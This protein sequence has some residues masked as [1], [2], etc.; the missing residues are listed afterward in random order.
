[1]SGQGSPWQSIGAWT[2]P[3]TPTPVVAG[4]T[5]T[6]QV[7]GT[8]ATQ[9]VLAY[10]APDSNPCTVQVSENSTLAPLVH[11]V[12]P[13]LF[14]GSNSDSRTGALSNGTSRVFVVGKRDTET[15]A[16]S[17]NYSRALQANT[18]HSFSVTCGSSTVTGTFTTQN[19]PLGMTNRDL[20]AATFPTVTDDLAQTIV[21]PHTGALLKKMNNSSAYSSTKFFPYLYFGGFVRMCATQPVGPSAGF[22]CAFPTTGGGP[23]LLWYITPS[24][25]SNYLGY[26]TINAQDGPNGWP[27][28]FSYAYPDI[29]EDG[30]L[31]TVSGDNSG[32]I[33]LLKGTFN[34][35]FGAV[36]GQ[37]PAT[38]Q[39]SNFTP[40]PNDLNAQMQAFDP[41][42]NPANYG[43]PG[44][45]PP[46]GNYLLLIYT[47]GQQDTPG[48][49]GV[50]DLTQG[51]IVAALNLESGPAVSYCGLHNS[52]V[53]GGQPLAN[54]G[55]HGLWGGAAWQGPFTTT[56]SSAID[57]NTTTIQIV[58]APVD[59][60]GRTLGGP[61]VGSILTFHGGA[62]E[63]VKVTSVTPNAQGISLQ[64]QRN[65]MP[66][67]PPW[68]PGTYQPTAHTA[69]ETLRAECTDWTYSGDL[70]MFWKFLQDPHGAN[71]GTGVVY[72]YQ[73]FGIGGHSDWGSNAEITEGWGIRTGALLQQIG[74]PATYSLQNSPTFGN[75]QGGCWG[76]S[77][78]M[79]PSYHTPGAQ[80]F[81]DGLSWD[82]GNYTYSD[83]VTPISGQLYKYRFPYN[84]GNFVPGLRNLHRKVVPTL[85][86]TGGT[87]LVDV[88]GPGSTISDQAADNY[89]YCIA[90]KAGECRTGSA[91]G[92]IFANVPA[93]D[94]LTCYGSDN[95]DPSV[96]DLCILDLPTYATSMVQI[97]FVPNH[98]GIGILPGQPDT[99]DTSTV[100]S[101]YSRVVTETLGGPKGTGLLFKTLP[102]GSWGFFENRT[103]PA[104]PYLMMAKIPPFTKDS[105]RRDVFVRAPITITP[106]TGQGIVSAEID[107]GYT[108]LNGK[109]SSRNEVCAV[110]SSTVDDTNPFSYTQSDSYVRAP[111][112]SSCTITLPVL[113]EHIAYYQVKYY[114][115]SGNF[116]ANGDSG[117]AAESAVATVNP[118]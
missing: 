13:K 78:A 6:V 108:E 112:S 42:F 10:T 118:R 9:A 16:D 32:H 20:P 37:Y 31:Y 18:Q 27:N 8:T 23:S 99:A 55:T 53:V 35:G 41:T 94:R 7:K 71:L 74:K 82:G 56:L 110:V 64:V 36:T 70:P 50:M 75:A 44:T 3:S 68:D 73:L 34:G 105:V 66:N 47:R 11:D 109:C 107:F 83:G 57:A 30:S 113:A 92:D 117:V 38:V 28:Q 24:G 58:G 67:L 84:D 52:Q 87:Q 40:A 1:M 89:K 114:G 61:Y 39:W 49:Y 5:L 88:S 29:A 111:C 98:E 97:G 90:Y 85:A 43:W 15:G 69:G 25:Q 4:Q 91:A 95:P 21:D 14:S 65:Y 45:S 116:I 103:G 62:S 86:T 17:V 22:L 19:I 79:H 104:S 26:I 33:V 102:D 76:S 77:C 100:G 54:I 93:I 63:P 101:G 96:R 59:A 12:D 48:W 115:A 106:P 2:V 81:T 72:D 51:K 60:N 80:W 46:I